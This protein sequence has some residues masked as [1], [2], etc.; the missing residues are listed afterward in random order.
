MRHS[1]VHTSLLATQFWSESGVPVPPP[2]DTAR[3][4][5]PLRVAYLLKMY[6]R[7][8]ETFILNELIELERR[9]IDLRVFSLMHPHDGRF[10]G[11][12]GKLGVQAQYFVRE[13]AEAYWNTYHSYS[14]ADRIPL[15]RWEAAREFLRRFKIPKDFDLLLRG[16]VIASECR[17]S[18][19]QHIHAHF[20]TISAQLAA[21][22]HL[23]TGIPFSFTSHAKDIFREDVDRELYR[24]LVELSA[25]NITVSD[26]N[27]QFLLDHTPG[28]DA[29]KVVRLYNGVDLQLFSPGVGVEEANGT[30]RPGNAKRRRNPDRP[31]LVSIGRLVPKKGFSNLL[32]AGRVLVDR[33]LDFELT[34]VGDGEDC[35]ALEQLSTQLE[36]DSRVHFAG[37]LPQEEVLALYRRAAAV[38]LACIPDDAG[39]QDALPTTLLEALACD[40]PVVSTVLTGVPEIASK[41]EGELAQPNDIDG[42]ALAI[43][44]CLERITAGDFAVGQCRARAEQLFD[45]PTNVA[46]LAEHFARSVHN[47]ENGA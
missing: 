1:L 46:S 34:I 13:H 44:R 16:V 38:V 6:P 43:Q 33:G 5:S 10:H 24:E 30:S 15:D 23:L 31:H 8:S 9:G 28:I 22:L 12:L 21:V 29:D 7:F 36:L 25:F 17:A 39:N 47:S 45:L 41:E 11:R 26:Y 40:V 3:N 37:G 32:R 18:G 35:A 4:E 19:V 42:L 2:A 14:E 20:A 27:R